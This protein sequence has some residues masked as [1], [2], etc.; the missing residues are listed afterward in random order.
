M[1]FAGE[2]TIGISRVPNQTNVPVNESTGLEQ[3]EHCST[4]VSFEPRVQQNSH[5]R[6]MPVEQKIQVTTTLV[7]IYS[8]GQLK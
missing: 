4:R 7:P 1:R 5:K 8:G 6:K 3:F 2:N